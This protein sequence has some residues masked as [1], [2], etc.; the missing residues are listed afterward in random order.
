MISGIKINSFKIKYI[1]LL[2][3]PTHVVNFSFQK[4]TI[5]D[6]PTTSPPRNISR[7]IVTRLRISSRESEVVRFWYPTCTDICHKGVHVFEIWLSQTF[8]SNLT[9]LSSP[10]CWPEPNGFQFII[11]WYFRATWRVIFVLLPENNIHCQVPTP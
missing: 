1:F 11:L 2:K 10:I 8:C 9:R 6:L 3:H 4:Y 5:H 7:I